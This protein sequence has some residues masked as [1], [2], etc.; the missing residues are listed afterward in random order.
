MNAIR[1]FVAISALAVVACST[2]PGG[3][4][5]AEL[6]LRTVDT[7]GAEQSRHC[8]PLPVLPGA[9]F[10]EEL[11]LGPGL[12][13]T[14]RTEPDFADVALS[15]TNDPASSHVTIPKAT[16]RNGYSKTVP[17]TTTSGIAYTVV[18]L[19]PCVPVDAGMQ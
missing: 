15:G 12:S 3:P 2:T 9:V 7:I 4:E 14:V 8:V 10:S 11:E 13:A 1:T 5:Y 16:L 6:G 19:S 17:V 18:L